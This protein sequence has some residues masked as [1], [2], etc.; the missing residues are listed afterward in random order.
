M[1]TK[2]IL[3]IIFI[4]CCTS[5]GWFI[6]GGALNMRT[7]S[8]GSQLSGA[9]ADGWG[10]PLQQAHPTAWINAP[11]T[12][13]GRMEFL[14]DASQIQVGLAFEPKKRGLLWHRTYAVRFN[15]EY[16]ITNPSPVTQTVYTTFVLPDAKTTYYNFTL[17]LGKDGP[18]KKTPVQGAL[19][20]AIEVPAGESTTLRVSYE[21]RGT[22]Q[23]TYT[24]AG[25]ERIRNFLLVLQTDFDSIDFP[26]GTGSPT[27]RESSDGGWRLAWDYPDV[28]SAPGI[29]MS[30]PSVV[31]AGPVA[32]RIV[33]F[34]PVSL[35]FFF[36]V[37]VILGMVRGENLHPMNYFFLAAGVFAFQ[38]LFAYLVD[39]LAVQ[40][41]FFL[42]AAVSLILVGTYVHA[43]SGGKLTRLAI[44]AQ[45]AYMVLFSYSFF[46]EGLTGLT[47]TIGAVATLAVLMRATASINW[48][49][50]FAPKPPNPS[51]IPAAQAA[52]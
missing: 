28:L 51:G 7:D 18:S 2:R 11:G 19:T 47:I 46:F 8:R 24:F 27:S 1:N 49:H 6:L 16:R 4:F 37:L 33:F 30:M 41:S 17:S 23:W 13:Q 36:A 40:A 42:A 25:A 14:P 15:G 29:G 32:S 44:L 9:V 52:A 35:L 38:L 39:V 3:A 20:E 48:G 5:I 12:A 43:V 21:T 22:D 26:L 45:S 10:P 50:A 31:N 34:A